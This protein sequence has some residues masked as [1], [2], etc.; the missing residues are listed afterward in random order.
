MAWGGGG[1]KGRI[2][3][4]IDI[5]SAN[6]LFIYMFVIL[7]FSIRKCLPILTRDGGGGVGSFPKVTVFDFSSD[8]HKDLTELLDI[9]KLV[10]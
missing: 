9:L 4:K 10:K 8:A 5:L 1:G 7:C 3:N 6:I 2:I